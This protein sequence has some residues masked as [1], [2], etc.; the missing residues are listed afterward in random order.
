MVPPAPQPTGVFVFPCTVEWVTILCAGRVAGEARLCLLV[1]RGFSSA[2]D[3]GLLG[4]DE[5]RGREG[6]FRRQSHSLGTPEGS[7]D[8]SNI[9]VTSASNCQSSVYRASKTHVKF[10]FKFVM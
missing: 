8:L 4:A 10:K 1:G 5:R 6:N 3:A 7:A 9:G 2:S